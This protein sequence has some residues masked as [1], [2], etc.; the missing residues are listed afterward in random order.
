MPVYLW[1]P[2]KT[3]NYARIDGIKTAV[4]Y[5]TAENGTIF[6]LLFYKPF[7]TKLQWKNTMVLMVMHF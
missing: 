3:I 5:I 2:V 7:V 1:I 4:A 6:A